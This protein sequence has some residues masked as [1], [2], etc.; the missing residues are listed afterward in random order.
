M[1]LLSE[2]TYQISDLLIPNDVYVFLAEGHRK[3]P[4]LIIREIYLS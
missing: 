4:D 2:N 3:T 1:K